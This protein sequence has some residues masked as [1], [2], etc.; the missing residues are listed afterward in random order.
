MGSEMCIRDSPKTETLLIGNRNP[1]ATKERA[2]K[3]EQKASI[4][5]AYDDMLSSLDDDPIL[6]QNHSIYQLP[7]SSQISYITI[8]KLSDQSVLLDTSLPEEPIERYTAFSQE[9]ENIRAK[10][11]VSNSL[12]S[13]VNIGDR[14]RPWAYKLSI[15]IPTGGNMPVQSL[16]LLISEITG[17]PLLM[18][19]SINSNQTFRFEQPFIDAFTALVFDRVRIVT[20]SQPFA[21]LEE[22]IPAEEPAVGIETPTTP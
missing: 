8:E 2:I 6:Y 9:I 11:F 21:P 1:E 18:G 16:Q 3:I 22:D 20:P 12:L 7:A 15:Y 14:L 17:G 13:S 5:Y 4:F 10:S 19:G